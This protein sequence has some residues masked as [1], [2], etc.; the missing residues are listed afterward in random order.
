MSLK[1][2]ASAIEQLPP[3]ELS[4]FAQWFEGYHAQAWDRQFEQDI[5]AGKLDKLA[6]QARAEYAAGRCKP[7]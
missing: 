5:A 3:A 6:E 2:I 7:L 4:E 1:E